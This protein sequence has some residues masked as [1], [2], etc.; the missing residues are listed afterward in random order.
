ML[1]VSYTSR[2]RLYYIGCNQE[3]SIRNHQGLLRY[4]LE[5]LMYTH[6]RYDTVSLYVC[7]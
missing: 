5:G 1:L 2:Y 3:Q 7:I 4:F 6:K